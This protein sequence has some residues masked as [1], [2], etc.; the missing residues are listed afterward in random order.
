M[1]NRF[2]NLKYRVQYLRVPWIR[3]SGTSRDYYASHMQE[4]L[5]YRAHQ[6]ILEELAI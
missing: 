2:S 3:I 6:I 5:Q 1:P 4:L